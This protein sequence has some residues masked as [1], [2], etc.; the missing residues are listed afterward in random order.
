[1]PLLNRGLSLPLR[2]L[3]ALIALYVLGASAY[4]VHQQR[5]AISSTLYAV[6]VISGIGAI[7]ALLSAMVICCTKRPSLLLPTALLDL[8]FMGGFVAIAVLLRRDA[9]TTCGDSEICKVD[10]TAFAVSVANAVFFLLLALLTYR[11]Y[12]AFKRNRAFGP[13]PDNGYSTTPT[14]TTGSRSRHWGS[15][16]SEDTAVT[17]NRTAGFTRHGGRHQEPAMVEAG[18]GY[19]EP[20]HTGARGSFDPELPHHHQTRE[21]AAHQGF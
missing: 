4:H 20:G 14:A 21:V 17:E 13:G 16:A 12:K 6:T 5:P 7:W 15:R 18:H 1:M 2:L 8:A 9:G 10:K 11:L 19:R 3:A